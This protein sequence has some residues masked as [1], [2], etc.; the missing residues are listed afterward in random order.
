MAKKKEQHDNAAFQQ[1]K[2]DLSAGTPGRLYIFHGEESY[3]R[4]HYF[5]KLRETLLGGGPAEFN[6]H[7]FQGKD[8]DARTLESAVDCLPMM[9]AR[10]LV[11]VTDYDLYKAP[12]AERDALIRIFKSLPDYCCVVF[13]YDLIAYKPDGRSKLA[14]AVKAAGS[15]VE[16]AH[17]EQSDL[18]DWI[19]RRFRALD[20]E[21]D[22]ELCRTLILRC[23]DLMNTLIPEIEKIGAYAKNARITRADIETVTVPRL[24]A[25][26]F[27]MTDALAAGNFDRAA[28]VLSELFRMQEPEQRISYFIGRQ[29]RQLYIARLVLEAHGGTRKLKELCGISYDFIAEKLMTSARQFSLAWCRRALVGMGQAEARAKN[30]TGGDL[31]EELLLLLLSLSAERGKKAC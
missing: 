8:F 13:I 19:Q 17:Q 14:G 23:G 22:S 27:D 26:V 31:K 18:V 30:G 9:S 4:D 28:E 7:A 10:T 25:V 6:L 5:G 2:R 24:D 12:E 11:S 3:L 21:I 1:L 15:V 20:R 29:F 16:F